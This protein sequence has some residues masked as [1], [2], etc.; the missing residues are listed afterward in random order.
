MLQ[1]GVSFPISYASAR[2]IGEE[3]RLEVPR[4]GRFSGYV[5]YANQSGLGEGPIT[6][7]L[8][9]GSDANNALTDTSKFSVSQD[10]RNTLRARIRF[11]AGRHLWFAAATQYG[12]GLP[13]EVGDNPDVGS[14][15]EQ[16]GPQVVSHVNL[17]IGGVGPNFSLDPATGA[18]F[19]R[20]E[21]RSEQFQLEATNITDRLNVI[22]FASLFSGTAALP[23]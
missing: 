5:S 19:Y 16:F 13:A 4:C 1:T 15:I 11:Q 22:N 14:L 23:K 20:K 10:Q 9:I 17:T 2:I 3:V 18:E 8:F 7:G 12:S 21:T 6:G